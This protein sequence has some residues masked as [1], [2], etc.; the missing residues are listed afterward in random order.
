MGGCAKRFS[1]FSS[2][3]CAARGGF[4]Q[5]NSI[6]EQR[7][8]QGMFV[9]S[10]VLL[11]QVVR[12]NRG[13]VTDSTVIYR[14]KARVPECGAGGDIVVLIYHA[15]KHC[16]KKKTVVESRQQSAQCSK[17]VTAQVII[18]LTTVN[19]IIFYK[20]KCGFLITSKGAKR[21]WNQ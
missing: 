20:V 18:N 15:V 7:N 12:G 9:S 8:K 10:C 13:A 6:K 1:L 11:P 2:C 4:G 17:C 16:D 21:T 14:Q 3:F 19:Q 5:S